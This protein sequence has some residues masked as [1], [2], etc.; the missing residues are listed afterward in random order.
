MVLE[1][2]VE[3]GAHTCIDRGMLDNTHIKRGVKLDNIIHIA[4][5]V[6]IGENTIM[7]GFCYCR[8]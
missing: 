6:V 7:A 2:N 8:Y 3:V 5:N 1:D 4:H